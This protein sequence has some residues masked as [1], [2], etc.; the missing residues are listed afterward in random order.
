MATLTTAEFLDGGVARTAGEVHTFNGGVLTVRTDTRWHANAPVS[1]TGSI[2]GS[3]IISP[4]LGGGLVLDATNV[5][6]MPYTGGSGTVPA[7]GTTITQG[8]VSGY[9]LGVWASATAAPT[10]VAAA[11]PA[12]GFLKFREVTGGRY[13]A[14]ALTGIAATAASPDVLGWI[15]VVADQGYNLS[16][17]RLGKFQTRGGWYE[18]G[19]TTGLANQA[20]QIPTNG[21]GSATE[22]PGLWIEEKNISITAASWVAGVATFT[23]SAPHGLLSF[24]G[25][26]VESVLPVSYNTEQKVTVISATQFTMP[27][28]A[29][30]GVYTSGGAMLQFEF[31]PAL[32]T[33]TGF[34]AANMS[35][36]LRCRF[37]CNVLS[38]ILRIGGDGTTAMA[39]LPPAGKRIRVPNIFLRQCVSTTRAVNAL[40]STT[41]AT[42]P[43][44]TTTNAGDID[45]EY[46]Y[47]DWYFLFSQPYRVKIW[48]SASFDQINISEAATALDLWDGITGVSTNASNNSLALTSNFAGGEIVE[49]GGP[50][51]SAA[52][53][54]HDINVNFCIGQNFRHCRAGVTTYARSSGSAWSLNQ[55]SNITLWECRSTNGNVLINTS[56]N[57]TIYNLDHV[58]RYRL[59]TI[60][61]T[62]LYAVALTNSCV[63]VLVDGM[64][65]GMKGLIADCHPYL[66]LVSYSSSSSIKIRNF[67]RRDAFLNG[68]TP[69]IATANIVA[70]FGN[71]LDIKVQRCYVV[72]T[73]TGAHL[74]VNSTKNVLLEDV[75]GD[76]A[77]VMS[78]ASLNT[79]VRGGGGT[80]SVTGQAAVYGSHFGGAFISDTQGRMWLALN[81]PT[82]ETEQ[83]TSKLFSPGSGFTSAGGL[84]LATAGDYFICEMQENRLQTTGFENIAATI[85]A[86]NAA[87]HTFEYQLDSGTGYAGAWKTLNGANLSAETVLPNVG[88]KLKFK[89][90]CTIAANNNLV[91]YV[92]CNTTST[93]AA[94][95][96]NLYP[97]DTN[98][99][100]FT[101]LPTG[102]DAVV[103]TAGTTTVLTTVDSVASTQFVYTYSGAQTVDIGFIK[104]GYEV[105]YIRGLPLAPI[106]TTIPVSLRLDRNFV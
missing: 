102:F 2:G 32:K 21:G 52:A 94:Q 12:T 15:E 55:C 18:L 75:Y 90:E 80:M 89:V 79:L 92:R 74:M 57:V 56:F 73:R 37:V 41:L 16:V 11:M 20:V 100:T 49:W 65:F 23:T 70:D 86:T 53:S 45:I 44:F 61:T 33:T 8:G 40:P 93:L 30:P 38:G 46:T 43:D 104:L 5:R 29:N 35:T 51:F 25:A 19:T 97:L 69:A 58:D 83:F 3:S 50:R 10:A 105:F 84:S 95:V 106:N 63:T 34:I 13:A 1:M 48:H 17:P 82:S 24:M 27:M 96:N 72:P 59:A 22:A 42:R 9:L 88:Y 14:G 77:D 4:T 87:N 36:D 7:I 66:G 98:T 76:F 31:Y 103:L 101:G 26:V 67:G 99:I 28:P 6:W 68:G 60:V 81:E 54:G 62:P 39:V 85:T 71:C 91:S 47:G 78:V 64:S